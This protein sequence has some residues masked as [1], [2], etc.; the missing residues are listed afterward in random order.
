MGFALEA[1]IRQISPQP[2]APAPRGRYAPSPTGLLHVGNARTALAAWL[3]IR[4]QHGAVIWRVE[5]L[6]GPRVVAGMGEAAWEDLEWLGLNWDE[7]PGIGGPHAPYLQSARIAAYDEA[8]ARLAQAG[9]LFPCSYSR[10]DLETLAS[11]PHGDG[12]VS[13]YPASLRPKTLPKTWIEEF[14]SGASAHLAV[15]FAVSNEPVSFTDQVY[16]LQTEQTDLAVGDF[17]VKRRDGLYAYQL[18]VVVDDA[19]M[20]ITEVVRGADLL[21]STGRQIQLYEALSLHTPAF[22]HL[23]LVLNAKGEKLSKRDSGLAIRALRHGGVP[24]DVL[25][26][27]LAFSLG[28]LPAPEPATPQDLIPHFSWDR[29]APEDWVLPEDLSLFLKDPQ[30]NR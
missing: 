3:S 18:A 20:G 26:G 12:T 2:T 10:K 11:A 22:A 1:G 21:S 17:V 27:Y 5:D 4:K 15:R 13:P 19:A 9:R 25:V 24:P 7:G 14:L 8:L 6:D 28:L 16:G 23:P 29:I 30:Q